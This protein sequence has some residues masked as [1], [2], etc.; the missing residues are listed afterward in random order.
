MIGAVVVVVV[1]IVGGGSR[2]GSSVRGL[3]RV[4]CLYIGVGRHLWRGRSF[5]QIEFV[6]DCVCA[7]HLAKGDTTEGADRRGTTT[8]R[9]RQFFGFCQP[10]EQT[11]L[12]L[13]FVFTVHGSEKWVG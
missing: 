5:F 8:R 1:V 3:G 12:L 9:R 13:T 10:L 2:R 11:L 7:V 4:G 6:F